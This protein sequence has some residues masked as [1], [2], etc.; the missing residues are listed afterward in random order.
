MEL[1]SN[2]SA[3]IDL[4]LFGYIPDSDHVTYDMITIYNHN[5]YLASITHRNP[6]LG[7]TPPSQ[8]A[9][10]DF[11]FNVLKTNLEKNGVSL[12]DITPAG[13]NATTANPSEE[14]TPT[15]TDGERIVLETDYI[16]FT[17]PPTWESFDFSEMPTCTQSEID[18][19]A[20]I[21]HSDDSTNINIVR[22][23]LDGEMALAEFVALSWEEITQTNPEYELIAED[24][25]E[26]DGQ[27]AFARIFIVPDPSVE[28]G[29]TYIYQI[30]TMPNT[31]L[32]Q[33]TVW[34]PSAEAL[35][36]HETD[37]QDI[38]ASIKLK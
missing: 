1:D 11:L 12:T 15:D 27:E 26:I 16:T 18:C 24:E 19:L 14:D 29:E 35:E 17:Y 38:I 22:I 8:Q 6:L 33:L 25:I 28:G 30:Y 31:D 20:V 7:S 13:D 3:E 23:P 21:I 34:A 4:L 9:I 10:D 37:I 32:I 5:Q 36:L 2:H